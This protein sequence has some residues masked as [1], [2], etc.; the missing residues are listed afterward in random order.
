MVILINV[1]TCYATVITLLTVLI[2]NAKSKTTLKLSGGLF[3]SHICGKEAFSY[4]FT[5]LQTAKPP[6]SLLRRHLLCL[7]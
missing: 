2:F 4:Q 3:S 1:F 7:N 5:I 6:N